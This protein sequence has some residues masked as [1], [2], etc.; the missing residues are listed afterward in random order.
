MKRKLTGLSRHY[1][2]ALRGH[3]TGSPRASLRAAQAFGRRAMTL[4]LETLDRARMHG[5]AL[6]KLVVP[7]FSP[8]TRAAIVR[9]AGAFFAEAITPKV[10]S[11]LWG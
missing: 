6:I 8:G 1:Q 7:T 3:L 10:K 2:A 9:R 4:G 5:Q 11:E